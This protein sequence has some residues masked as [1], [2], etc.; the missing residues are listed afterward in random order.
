MKEIKDLVLTKNKLI[1]QRVAS[2]EGIPSAMFYG[3][4]D[5]QNVGK[6]DYVV[7]SNRDRLESVVIPAGEKWIN[8]EGYNNLWSEIEDL[9]K[10]T[11]NQFER[12]VNLN[13]FPDDYYD[14]IN[15]IRID[16]TRRRIEQMDFTGLMTVELNNPNFSKAVDLLEF[17]PFAGAFE[18]IKGTGDNVPM[19]EQKTG[20]KGAVHIYLYGLGHART[21]EDELYNLDIFS[22]EKVNAAVARGHTALR[23]D[24]CLGTLVALTN[25]GAWNAFQTVAATT[26]GSLDQRYYE[27]I[28]NAIRQLMGLRDPQTGQEIDTSRMV[29]VVGSNVIAWDLNR[30]LSGRVLR[31]ENQIIN[32]EALP[33][34][35]VWIYKGDTINVGPRPHAYPGVPDG[36]AYLLVPGPAG[37]PIWTLNKRQL[38]ME[39]GRGDVLQLARERRAWYFGQGEYQE[40]FLGSSG[41]LTLDTSTGYGYVVTID[42]PTDET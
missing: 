39:I 10:R 14:L 27:T 33:I 37:S 24:L 2:G 12:K 15:R 1:K 38:T 3:K 9:M 25:A 11:R 34:D 8:S 20:A 22:L 5:S 7:K 21:L 31:G 26:T 23:N 6:P 16:I 18:E 35:D 13:Q 4:M 17:I 28:R 41:D 29:L 42:L 32:L 19:L 36:T 40:E 30:V